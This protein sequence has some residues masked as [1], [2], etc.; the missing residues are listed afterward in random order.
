MVIATARAGRLSAALP[1][2][3]PAA[4]LLSFERQGFFCDRNLLEPSV[5]KALIPALDKVYD[6]QQGKAT[7]QGYIRVKFDNGEMHDYH[8]HS[9]HKLTVVPPQ[10]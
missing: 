6:E 8:V 7:R 10:K 3:L 1:R 4:D 9:L 2:T 5:V